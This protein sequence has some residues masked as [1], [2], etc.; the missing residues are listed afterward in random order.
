M[1]LEKC[2]LGGNGNITLDHR[3][4]LPGDQAEVAVGR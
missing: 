1:H 2:G 3:A 4:G